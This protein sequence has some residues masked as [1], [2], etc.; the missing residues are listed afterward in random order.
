VSGLDK[1]VLT[2][3]VKI[4][5]EYKATIT[6]KNTK[7]GHYVSIGD[8]F[9]EFTILDI[10]HDKVILERDGET[11][12]LKINM[13]ASHVLNKEPVETE[14]ASPGTPSPKESNGQSKKLQHRRNIMKSI[15]MG[16][17]N[18]PRN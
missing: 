11:Y 6:D 8:A 16:I 14:Q 10:K 15:R 2:G 7:D 13:P 9:D 5:G 12:E 17:P 3:I 18:V 1:Y 4:R